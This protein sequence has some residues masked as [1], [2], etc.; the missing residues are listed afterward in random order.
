MMCLLDITNNL[1]Y[2]IV[3]AMWYVKESLSSI[4]ALFDQFTGQWE[5]AGLH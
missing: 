4:D 5:H 3:F 2:M 1:F